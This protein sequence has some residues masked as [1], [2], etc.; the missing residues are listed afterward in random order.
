MG[1]EVSGLLWTN[2]WIGGVL[3]FVGLSSH[4]MRLGTTCT[5]QTQLIYL[6]V[7]ITSSEEWIRKITMTCVSDKLVKCIDAYD[8]SKHVESKQ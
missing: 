8:L 6:E 5:S 4:A 7:T 1:L 3:L 2:S